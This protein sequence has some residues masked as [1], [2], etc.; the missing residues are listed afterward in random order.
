MNFLKRLKE[1]SN[2][3]NC[4]RSIL[5]I[6]KIRNSSQ[7]YN[8]RLLGEIIRETHGIEK[9]LS[10]ENVRLGFGISKFTESRHLLGQYRDNDGNMRSEPLLMY[11]DAIKS[12]L[13]FHKEKQFSNDVIKRV[14]QDYEKLNIEIGK[15]DSVYGG[16]KKV[17]RITY[18][19]KEKELLSSIF[20]NRHSIRE[21]DHTPVNMN[22]LTS[23]IKLAMNCPSA[24]NRQ[25]Q[26]LYIIDKKDFKSL[27]NSF[28]GTGGFAE[29]LDKILFITGSMSSYRDYEIFQWI[30]TGSIF[31]A[32]LSLALEIYSIGSCFIQRPLLPNK[33]WGKISSIIGAPKDEQLICCMGIGNLKESYNVPV[34]HRL[35]YDTIVSYVDLTKKK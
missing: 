32:Y 34:S 8:S 2:L 18:E 14:E 12:Y 23:A 3:W 30:V 7:F 11:V 19:D 16:I 35:S 10:L 29:D 33:Q 17:N 27:N 9:G 31:A 6:E 1:I 22:N 24:C 15:R 20:T 28:E 21:F 26:R 5:Y 25:C 4:F 13:E